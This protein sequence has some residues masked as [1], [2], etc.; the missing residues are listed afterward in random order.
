MATIT[1]EDAR[2][3]HD[4][5]EDPHVIVENEEHPDELELTEWYILEI[6]DCAPR[7]Y[8][9]RYI[10][11]EDTSIWDPGSFDMH[12]VDIGFPRWH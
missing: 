10:S 3:T 8:G 1:Q 2:G 9:D 5:I 6:L 7:R 11:D 12:G 4:L